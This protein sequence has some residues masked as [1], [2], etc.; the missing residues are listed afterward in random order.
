MENESFQKIR[1]YFDHEVNDAVNGILNQDGFKGFLY[2]F[3]YPNNLEEGIKRVSQISSIR[4]FQE[5]V[6][7]VFFE[8]IIAQ[9]IKEFTVNGLSNIDKSKRYVFISSHRDIVLDSALLQIA[10][11]RNGFETTRSAIGN[12]LVPSN[13]LEEIAKLNKMFLVIRDGSVREM[14]DNS[15]TLSS[16]IRKSILEDHESVWIAQRNGRTKDG[17]DKTQQGL[18]KMLAQCNKGV[19]ISGLQ[20][21]NIVPLSISYEYEPCDAL[22]AREKVIS[23]HSVYKKQPGEDFNSIN[24]GVL[25]NKGRVQ[26]NIGSPI[27]DLLDEIESCRP[28]NDMIKDITLLIDRQ[29]HS[30]N[31]LWK[32]NYIAADLINST[33]HYNQ[34]YTSEEEKGFVDYVENLVQHTDVDKD[35]F[36]EVLLKIY[37][38]PVFNK[39][40]TQLQTSH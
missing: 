8:S 18:L 34:F 36:R 12:N 13:L 14:F 11:Y 30:V 20:D 7:S 23:S 38:N 21:L 17:N 6:S 4:E 33:S 15:L 26:I 27:N 25:Q 32:T 31:K 1:P 16:Y 3:L 39:T 24:T 10:L 40:K 5:V 37:A 35:Q 28:A 9:T 22:K 19:L 29:I 2:K